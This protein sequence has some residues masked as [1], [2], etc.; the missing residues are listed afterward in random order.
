MQ[1][2]RGREGQMYKRGRG[3]HARRLDEHGPS[4]QRGVGRAQRRR[5][6]Q[7]RGLRLRAPPRHRQAGEPKKRTGHSA[8]DCACELHT[9]NIRNKL[10]IVAPDK[11]EEGTRPRGRSRMRWT[12]QIKAAVG[13]LL[14]LRGFFHDGRLLRPLR[15]EIN[16]VSRA[17]SRIRGGFPGCA[18]YLGVLLRTPVHRRS[19]VWSRGK[20]NPP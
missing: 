15:V 16:P 10:I 2:L 1:I 12:A 18:G 20:L 9:I 14:L 8:E 11:L 3:P 7:R 4:A 17:H 19:G 5:R 6:R 13:G